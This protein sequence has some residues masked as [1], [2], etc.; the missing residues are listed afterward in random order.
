MRVIRLVHGTAGKKKTEV[1]RCGVISSKDM[2]GPSTHYLL[3][4]RC[5]R[6]VEEIS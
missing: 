3:T 6:A 1:G 5:R 4:R 2:P